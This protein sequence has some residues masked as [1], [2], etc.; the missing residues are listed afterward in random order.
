MFLV[1]RGAGMRHDLNTKISIY[2]FPTCFSRGNRIILIRLHFGLIF[3]L[4]LH[5]QLK[6]YK[7]YQV[8]VIII[9]IIVIIVIIYV[10]PLC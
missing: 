4:L 8:Y 5:R 2:H 7:I 6:Y 9:L 3:R 1:G 10:S